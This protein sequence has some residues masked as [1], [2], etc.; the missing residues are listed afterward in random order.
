MYAVY[1]RERDKDVLTPL[2]YVFPFLFVCCVFLSGSDDIHLS[3]NQ[4]IL[5]SRDR[6]HTLLQNYFRA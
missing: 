5:P 4:C 6:K 1:Q 2:N 3:S